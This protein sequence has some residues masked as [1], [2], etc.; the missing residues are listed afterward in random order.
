VSAYVNPEASN[1]FV[2]AKA[3]TQ[4]LKL[5]APRSWL[6]IPACAGMN[7]NRSDAAQQTLFPSPLVGE[8]KKEA[9]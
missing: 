4:G 3:G 1:P 8:G 2:P 9:P 6:W 5:L 7:G